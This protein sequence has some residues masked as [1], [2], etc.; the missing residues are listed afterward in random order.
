[1]TIMAKRGIHV[2]IEKKSFI[3]YF[4]DFKIYGELIHDFYLLF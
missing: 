2:R 4:N 1:M 3:S